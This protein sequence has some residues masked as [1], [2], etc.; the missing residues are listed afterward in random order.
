MVEQVIQ[1]LKVKFFRHV[2]G[3]LLELGGV[4]IIIIITCNNCI[5][6]FILSTSLLYR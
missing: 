3:C 6:A 4:I 1:G 5:I 2:I